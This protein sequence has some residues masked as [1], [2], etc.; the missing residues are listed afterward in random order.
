MRNPENIRYGNPEMFYEFVAMMRS[1][2]SCWRLSLEKI[3]NADEGYKI[4]IDISYMRK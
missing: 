3:N 1:H 2:R 4:E